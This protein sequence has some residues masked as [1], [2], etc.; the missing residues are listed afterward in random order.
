MTET[1]CVD[2]VR[3]GR[4]FDQVLQGASEVFM[5]DGFEG[6]SVD[7]IARAAGVS[8]ATLYSYFPDKRLLFAEVAAEQCR[9][10]T[11]QLGAEIDRDIPVGE[12]LTI[13]GCSM[14]RFLLSDTGIRMSRVVMSE[15]ERFPK[16][17]RQ[18][19]ETGPGNGRKA[20][21]ELFDGSND[22]G[23]TQIADTDLAAAQF[24]ELCKADHWSRRMLGVIDHVSDAEID[25][26][27]DEAVAMFM[28]RYG[29]AQTAT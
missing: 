5:R 18:F 15:S 21:R 28:A 16:L 24:M 17:G 26:V 27:I 3:K 14:M 29:T 7:D 20:L 11:D 13:A 4:K 1:S 9:K 2:R 22:K 8:K 12:I 25:R 19:Y 6:A 10:Q 23:E